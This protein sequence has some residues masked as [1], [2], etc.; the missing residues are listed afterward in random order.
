M[1]EIQQ[2]HLEKLIR[3]SERLQVVKD[4]LSS[5]PIVIDKAVLQALVN[6]GEK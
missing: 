3:E 2:A 1:A 6:G 5:A 4:Y